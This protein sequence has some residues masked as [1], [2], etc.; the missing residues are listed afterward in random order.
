MVSKSIRVRDGKVLLL[1][2]ALALGG[3][4]LRAELIDDFTDIDTGLS[5][6]SYS[7]NNEVYTLRSTSQGQKRSTT[8]QKLDGATVFGTRRK[9]F[10][11][12]DNTGTNDAFIQ[13]D[14]TGASAKQAT[15]GVHFGTDSGTDA[16]GFWKLAYGTFAGDSTKVDITD[17]GQ[18]DRINI[19]W[20]STNPQGTDEGT[21]RVKDAGGTEAVLTKEIGNVG[22]TQWKF[23]N[24]MVDNN[25]D[26]GGD[27]DFN[28]LQGMKFTLNGAP[29]SDFS[30]DSMRTTPL[31]PAL[32]AGLAMLGG[33]AGYRRWRKKRAQSDTSM[34]GGLPVRAT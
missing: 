25:G 4:S 9:N 18:Q 5:T 24:F 23:D 11:R 27:L 19:D 3:G 28:N 8:H 1:G 26:D 17:G 33:F 10:V 32:P 12:E 7:N 20:E 6:G 16:E 14:T 31:P 15:P 13:V 2:A 29:K 21:W 30:T 34:A 22:S